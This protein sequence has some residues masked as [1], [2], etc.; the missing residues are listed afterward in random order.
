MEFDA[1]IWP[2]LLRYLCICL[3]CA[4]S[5]WSQQAISMPDIPE[6]FKLDFEIAA[7]LRPELE[8]Q[9]VPASGR[10]VTGR[11]VFERLVAQ[12]P[13]PSFKPA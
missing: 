11:L 8:A 2:L 5:A 13:A 12:V 6:K 7:R 9:S 1:P 3:L 10:F 4:V